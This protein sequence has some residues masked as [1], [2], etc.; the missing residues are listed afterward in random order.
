[1]TVQKGEKKTYD[2][3]LKLSRPFRVLLF[4]GCPY[5]SNPPTEGIFSLRFSVGHRRIGHGHQSAKGAWATVFRSE[6]PL[7]DIL[8]GRQVGFIAS[9][10]AGTPGIYA[11]MNGIPRLRGKL[12]GAASTYTKI[13]YFTKI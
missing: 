13:T 9:F 4:S 10:H 11:P 5:Q 2:D 8:R 1:M 12:V 3:A 6:P 7:R